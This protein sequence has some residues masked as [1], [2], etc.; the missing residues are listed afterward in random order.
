M[1]ISAEQ[2]KAMRSI[3]HN[4][5]PVVTIA[6]NGLSE[7]VLDELNRALDDH[8]LIKV[9]IAIG[10]RDMRAQAIDEMVKETKSELIQKI[11]KVALI[12][13]RNPKA[14]PKLSNLS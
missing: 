1:A 2:K 6:G 5:N 8:E 3:G 14:H 11:G 7:T 13:R 9:K 4:L 12:V 10:E